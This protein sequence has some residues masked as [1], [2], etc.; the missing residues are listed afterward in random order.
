MARRQTA[1]MRA[2]NF[3]K[4]S[5]T[6]NYIR[7]EKIEIEDEEIYYNRLYKF[8]ESWLLE[9][10]IE[11]T[12]S[13]YN[14]VC[15]LLFNGDISTPLYDRYLHL[16]QCKVHSIDHY[17]CIYGTT[18]G[19]K[20]YAERCDEL[21]RK[22][23]KTI[24]PEIFLSKLYDKKLIS[25]DLMVDP[26]VVNELGVIIRQHGIDNL[27][28]SISTICD[29]IQYHSAN[30]SISGRYSNTK[31]FKYSTQD[32]FNARYGDEG[33][34]MYQNYKVRNSLQA[35][36]NFPNNTD[37]WIVRGYNTSSAIQK[38]LDVQKNR[39]KLSADVTKGRVSCR[40]FEYW[41]KKGIPE[42]D[43]KMIVREMQTRDLDYFIR[44]YGEDLGTIKFFDMI[45]ARTKSWESK[46]DDERAL[47][48]SKKGRTIH[49]LIDKFGCEY[50]NDIIRR[51]MSSFTG[52]SQESID[53]F[54]E[55]DAML[56]KELAEKS[57]TAYKGPERWIRYNN[58]I[59]FVDYLIDNCVIEY[60]GSFW[61]ADPK[62]YQEQDY[63]DVIGASVS[64]IWKKD[65]ERIDHIKSLSY[66]VLVIWSL[67]VVNDREKTL[68]LCRDFIHEHVTI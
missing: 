35:K 28:N 37:Y 22:L 3:F 14:T 55:L 23:T 54:S 31:K 41:V 33:E 34:S 49:Q 11:P 45:N 56:P 52:R 38:S 62:I 46:N 58:N 44:K 15:R 42:D 60:H 4:K 64:S 29:I 10:K 51:R 67:D 7:N 59:Y 13:L 9:H 47:I 21:S 48:N 20:L 5:C 30:M 8:W 18:V 53:F 68:Q 1:D 39:A 6:I 27:S 66:N 63:H 2:K 19:T 25:Y 61:H 43:A 65:S 57:I 24:T 32:Y 17:V 16:K 26:L 50:A 36:R 40:S 12:N